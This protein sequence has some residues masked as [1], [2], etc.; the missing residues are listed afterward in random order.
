RGATGGSSRSRR[1]R[2]TASGSAAPPRP[3]QGSPISPTATRREWWAWIWVSTASRSA[4]VSVHSG[5]KPSAG[6]TPLPFSSAAWSVRS[7]VAASQPTA[8]TPHTSCSVARMTVPR[9][10]AKAGS[11]RWQWLS[12]I[13]PRGVSSGPRHRHPADQERW[14]AGAVPEHEVVSHSLDGVQHVEQV[15]GHRDLLHRVRQLAVLDPHPHRAPRVVA[16][17]A[18]DPEADQ[19]GDVEAVLHAADQVA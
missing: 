16:G 10:S 17:D 18:V 2:R 15:A 5:W 4:G 11:C 9:T 6:Q 1:S 14:R 12:M 13:M 7:F 8:T 19:L 3:Y